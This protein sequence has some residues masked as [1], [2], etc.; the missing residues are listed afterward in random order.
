VLNQ[1]LNPNCSALF[2]YL[3]EGRIFTV[4][5]FVTSANEERTER[6]LEHYWL[7]ETCSKSMKVVVENGVATTV[8]MRVE[9]I[10]E[11]HAAV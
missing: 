7:C 1:C 11:I 3:Y 2:R 9:P 4:E 5:R 8:P 6:Q 10:L